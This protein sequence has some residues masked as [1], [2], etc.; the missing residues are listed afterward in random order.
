M[1]VLVITIAWFLDA[2]V[3]IDGRV[4]DAHGPSLFLHSQSPIP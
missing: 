3:V 4:D 1:M 2:D